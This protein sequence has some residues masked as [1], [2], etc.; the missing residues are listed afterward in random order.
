MKLVVVTIAAAAF[1]AACVSAPSGQQLAS[2]ACS[3]PETESQ[4]FSCGQ[5]AALSPDA[6]HGRVSA[7][8]RARSSRGR[9]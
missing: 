7:E 2:N 6:L 9:N 4:G 8:S 5:N 1:A 3:S